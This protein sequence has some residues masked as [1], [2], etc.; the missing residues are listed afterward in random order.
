MS[1]PQTTAGARTTAQVD[2]ARAPAEPDRRSPQQGWGDGPRALLVGAALRDLGGG[3]LSG[4]FSSLG[5][6]SPFLTFLSPIE[7]HR[8][9]CVQQAAHL[10]VN[11]TKLLSERAPFVVILTAPTEE[12]HGHQQ[13]S[14]SNQ[15]CY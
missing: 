3:V 6:G 13:K 12:T 14:T 7:Q 11:L 2:R 15:G 8:L 1:V 4:C 10:V 5:R 9:A